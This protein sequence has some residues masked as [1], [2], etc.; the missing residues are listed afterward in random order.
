MHERENSPERKE[1]LKALKKQRKE[2]IDRAA[3]R[4]KR[5]NQDMGKIKQVLATGPR[6]V[7]EL[8]AAAGLST[9]ETLW[10]VMAMKKYGQVAEGTK[11][12]TE[13]YYPYELVS[14]ID[15]G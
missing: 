11:D 4:V 3:E 8:A 14:T 6:T 12:R 1:A 13:T 9:A 7:P 2:F 10:Y 15:R 5:V